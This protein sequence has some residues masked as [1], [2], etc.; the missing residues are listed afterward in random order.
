MN[1]RNKSWKVLKSTL[2][3][4]NPWYKVRK[5]KVLLPNGVVIKDYFVSE[6]NSVAMVFAITKSNDVVFVK[7]YRHP[8]KKVLLELPAGIYSSGESAKRVASRELLEE[9]GYKARKLTS[10]GRIL[11]YPTKDSHET[12]LFL[13][14]DVILT[15]LARPEATEDIEVVLMPIN[16]LLK[17]VKDEQIFVSGAISCI[18]KALLHLNKIDP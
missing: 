18:T 6:L 12:R 13:A 8:V 7:Q 14:E 5:D 10:L 16:N 2:V 4:N 9:T 15:K 17:L 1:Y 11:G 3:L